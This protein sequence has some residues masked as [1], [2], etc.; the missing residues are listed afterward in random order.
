MKYIFFLPLLFCLCLTATAQEPVKIDN[1]L[2]LDYYQSQRFNEAYT[3]LTTTYPEPVTDT[4]ALA[5]LAYTSRMAGK[6]SE[7][8]NYY[9]RVY[10]KDSSN[11]A[12][13]FSLGSINV[14]RGNNLKAVVYYKKILLRDSTNFNVYKQLASLSQNLM[15]TVTYSNY[16]QKANILN[17]QE[18]DVAFD[19]GT[20]YTILKKYDQAALILDKAIE[21]DTSN[22]MLL[23]GK[24]QVSFMQKK[25]PETIALCLKLVQ[26]GDKQSAIINWLGMSYFNLK[27]YKSCIDT[28]Q[29]MPMGLQSEA[30][31]YYVAMSYKGLKDEQ[32]AI[33]YL[34][35]TI[36]DAVSPNVNDYYNE[37]ADS[38]EKLHQLKNSAAAYQKSLQFKEKPLT[39]YLLASLYDAQLKNEKSA[40]KY[41]KKFLASKPAEKDKIYIDYANTRI[42]AL[43]H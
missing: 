18:P 28:Y 33:L 8:E 26:A 38:Y 37:I 42:A 22:L 4:K 36:N 13:L 32:N 30:V 43:N 9:L 31:F 24:A 39:Y 21:A 41:Y 23:K 15:D 11:I 3:Y 2:L 29:L 19:L 14:S 27:Q 34:Q 20:L 25:Y 12:T 6:L 17:P 40:V 7:A 5:Q 35:K 1:V 10:A 16:L